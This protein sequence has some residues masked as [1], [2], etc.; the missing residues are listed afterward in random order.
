[1]ETGLSKVSKVYKWIGVIFIA[2]G[3]FLLVGSLIAAIHEER[4]TS[5]PVY[6]AYFLFSGLFALF[7][8]YVGQAIDDIR[9]SLNKNNQEQ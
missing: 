9:N 4:V 8:A 5:E 2:L 6:G 3:L 1:M 7:A